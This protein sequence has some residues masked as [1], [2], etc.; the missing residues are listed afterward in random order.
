MRPTRLLLIATALLGVAL[1]SCADKEPERVAVPPT[2]PN[3]KIPWNSVGPS[4]AGA[5]FNAMPQ[6]KYRR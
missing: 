4:G 3:S 6:N 5:Q 2:S 1:A